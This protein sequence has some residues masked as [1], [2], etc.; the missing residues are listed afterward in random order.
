M[1]V[2]LTTSVLS[3]FRKLLFATKNY[4]LFLISKGK[5]GFFL[6][7]YEYRGFEKLQTGVGCN[8]Q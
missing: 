4:N 2:G 3:C 1:P 8:E 6:N 7:N 5:F